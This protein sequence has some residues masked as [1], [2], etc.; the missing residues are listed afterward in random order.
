MSTKN[1]ILLFFSFAFYF[2]GIISNTIFAMLNGYRY[3]Y[4]DKTIFIINISI[5]ILNV[6]GYYILHKYMLR[7][8]DQLYSNNKEE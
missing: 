7:V 1:K 8:V 4:N 2:F 5:S 3:D 6:L